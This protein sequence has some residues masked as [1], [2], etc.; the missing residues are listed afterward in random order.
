MNLQN[1]AI[2]PTM[3]LAPNIINEVQC[4]ACTEFDAAP[5]VGFRSARPKDEKRSVH[6]QSEVNGAGRLYDESDKVVTPVRMIPM[7]NNLTGAGWA[8]RRTQSKTKFTTEQEPKIA[9]FTPAT[10]FGHWNDKMTE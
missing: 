3:S 6:G 2:S 9:P 1:I 10:T 7:D 5:L 4:P 8:L